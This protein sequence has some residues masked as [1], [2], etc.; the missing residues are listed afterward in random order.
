[1][2][3]DGPSIFQANFNPLQLVT[4]LSGGRTQKVP[5]A[6]LSEADNPNASCC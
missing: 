3:P 1:M 6:P 2:R 4:D 5:D